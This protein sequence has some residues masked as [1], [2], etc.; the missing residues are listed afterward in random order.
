M[1]V[2]GRQ[3]AMRERLET[4]SSLLPGAIYLWRQEPDGRFTVPY[5]SEGVHEIFGATAAEAMEDSGVV[6]R[7]IH[8]SDRDAYLASIEASRRALSV[9][10]HD[11]RIVT[12]DGDVRWLSAQAMPERLEDGATVWTGFVADVTEQRAMHARLERNEATLRQVTDA[13]QDVVVMADER[14]RIGFVTPSVQGVLGLDP[15]AIQGL[16]I[17]ELFGPADREAV[18]RVIEGEPDTALEARG[19]HAHGH[20]VW[21]EV[22][23]RRVAENG[24]MVLAARDVTQRVRNRKALQRELAYRRTLVELT[25]DMLSAELDERFY[26]QLMERAIELVPDAEGGSMVLW[27]DEDGRYRFVAARGFDIDVLRRIRM[28]TEELARSDP[29]RVERIRIQDVR[30]RLSSDTV[31]LFRK[32]GRLQDIRMTLSVPIS[33]GGRARGFLNLDNFRGEDAFGPEAIEVAEAL[34][35]QVGLAFQRL[36]LEA[37]LREERARYQHLAGHD[38]LTDLPNR[39]LF[40]DRLDQALTRAA[41]RSTR[42]GLIYVDLDDFKRVNDEQGHAAGDELLRTVAQ[43][44]AATVRAEDTVAR[45]GGDEFAVVL[46]ELAGPDDARL[47]QR[48]T[49]RG[50]VRP[51]RPAGCAHP[52]SRQ[53]RPSRASARRRGRRG[54]D[55]GGGR[56]DVPAEGGGERAPGR[57]LVRRLTVDGQPLTDLSAP[58]TPRSAGAYVSPRPP[59]ATRSNRRSAAAVP[60]CTSAMRTCSS[61]P[62]MRLP[63]VAAAEADDGHAEADDEGVDR[64]R[65]G[66]VGVDDRVVAVR[67]PQGGD[68]LPHERGVRIGASSALGVLEPHDVDVVEAVA[69]KVPLDRGQHRQRILVGHEPHVQFAHRPARKHRLGALAAVARVEAVHVEGGLEGERPLPSV[70]GDPA[71]PA[72][73]P[74]HLAKRDLLVRQGVHQRH[75]AIRGRQDAVTEA[76]HEHGAVRVP[77]RGERCGQAPGGVVGDRAEAR[78]EVPPGGPHAQLEGEDPLHAAVRDRPASGVDAAELPQTAIS[79]QPLGVRVDVRRQVRAADLLF[80]LDQKRQTER[81]LAVAL[82]VGAQRREAR[83]QLAL[84]VGRPAPVPG[85]V[86]FGQLERRRGPGVQRVLRLHVVVVV[87]QQRRRARHEPLREHDGRPAGLVQLGREAVLGQQLGDRLGRLGNRASVRRDGGE[88]HEAAQAVVQP[89]H[90]VGG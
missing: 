5:A 74:E 78:V 30:G 84:V 29:P 39:R 44:L 28:T 70:A 65:S 34:A 60:V 53:R 6:L 47:G 18:R 38:P 4:L 54:A 35:A 77:Q 62:W 66:A 41:R 82:A 85:A 22:T 25:S 14:Y 67:L 68:R 83:D 86:A 20:E 43:R 52:A 42:V 12:D 80:P 73:D 24:G 61:G 75:V 57:R 15:A 59:A 11:F 31:H 36:R 10:K 37:S 27:D 71:E 46:A 69:R 7:T 33:A 56:R 51:V 3:N 48:Q 40:Q 72:I 21:L 79:A 9:W 50:D 81:K 87:Q 45:L 63:G 64:S 8:P 13:L 55:A 89:R 23:A 90:L 17:Y 16:P 58:R 26:Q 88:R 76:V 2:D 19:A 1:T 49:A 32:A